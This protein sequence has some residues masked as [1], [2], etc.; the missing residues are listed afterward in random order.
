MTGHSLGAALATLAASRLKDRFSTLFT[1]GAPLVGNGRFG[2][3]IP[4]ERHQRYV[5]CLDLVTRIPPEQLGFAHCGTRH[6]ID[7]EGKIHAR[8]AER[9]IKRDTRSARVDYLL[10]HAW[11]RGTVELREL[12]DH[13]PINYVSA[14]L[15]KRGKKV[16]PPR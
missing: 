7:S 12:A 8:I 15:G 11:R 16:E 10:K 6:Y 1:F 2:K 13:A 3:T 9:T 4:D 14:L 5:N